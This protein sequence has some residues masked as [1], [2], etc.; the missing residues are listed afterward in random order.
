[1]IAVV[2]AVEQGIGAALVPIPIAEQWFRQKTIFQLFDEELVAD[3]S[4]FLIWQ[5]GVTRSP[6]VAALRDWIVERV[7]DPA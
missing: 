3:V 6:G 7:A 1:M 5:D 4:Y 2:R